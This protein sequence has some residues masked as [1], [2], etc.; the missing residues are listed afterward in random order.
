[1]T[2]QNVRSAESSLNLKAAA[3]FA[4]RAATP[5][6]DKVIKKKAGVYACFFLF[7]GCFLVVDIR[8]YE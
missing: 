5:N 3:I 2:I 8:Y 6:A 4:V 7:F 1:M